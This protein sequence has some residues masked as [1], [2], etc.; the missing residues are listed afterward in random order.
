M[1]TALGWMSVKQR[2]VFRSLQLIYKLRAGILPE[3][4]CELLH[5]NNEVHRYQNGRMDDFRLPLLKKTGTQNSL[6]Y[7]GPKEFNEMPNDIK[8]ET[9][10]NIFK[11]KLN[12][13]VRQKY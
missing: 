10:F 1:L 7:K 2:V 6:L 5:K 4:L 8:S 12:D 11:R 3:Y 13:Y 9:N